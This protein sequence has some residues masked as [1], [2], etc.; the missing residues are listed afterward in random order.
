MAMPDLGEKYRT[1][2]IPEIAKV[3]LIVPRKATKRNLLFDAFRLIIIII[4]IINT[5]TSCQFFF[6]EKLFT[7][8][9]ISSHSQIGMIGSNKNHL[10]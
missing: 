6:V 9:S 2:W 1:I 5:I 3:D 7:A 10:K 4:I 8:P